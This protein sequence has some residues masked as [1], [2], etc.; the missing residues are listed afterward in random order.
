MTELHGSWCATTQNKYIQLIAGS[1]A[2]SNH[3]PVAFHWINRHCSLLYRNLKSRKCKDRNKA[4][5][6][7]N[8]K[9]S[10]SIKEK[11]ISWVST[12]DCENFQSCVAAPWLSSANLMP[13]RIECFRNFSAH[14]R[15]Q[16][17]SCFCKDLCLKVSTQSLKH[18]STS[19]LYILKLQGKYTIRGEI[20]G[21]E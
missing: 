12:L 3:G 18:L 17:S 10:K 14:R 2:D 16:V 20:L 13:T 19:E 21:Q 8:L 1:P 4:L 7:R 11:T 5:L 6:I 9:D 15:T